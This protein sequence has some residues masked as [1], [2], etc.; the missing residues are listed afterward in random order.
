MKLA[1]ISHKPCWTSSNSASGYATD[2]GFPY[3]M[4]AL[5]E[6]FD[7]THLVVPCS[8]TNNLPG[9]ISLH[10]HNLSVR[11][12]QNPYGSGIWRKVFILPWLVL[13][14][15]I[16]FWEILQSDAVHTPI[17][18]D[19]GTIGMVLCVLMQKRL[20]VRHCGNWFVQTTVIE[21]F[22]KWFMERYAGG[23]RVMLVTGGSS[24][25]PSPSNPAIRWIFATTLS[26]QEL[27]ICKAS[28]AL[29]TQDSVR[30]IIVCRQ[31]WDKGTD[32]VIKSMPIVLSHFPKV[33]L[34]VVGDGSA[35]G[36]L[37]RLAKD[38]KV[39]DQII[40][41]GRVDHQQVLHLLG[42]AHL[43]C[44][45][46]SSSDGFPKVVHEALA[47]G[48]PVITTRVSVLPHLLEAGCGVLINQATPELVA[49]A[50]CNILRNSDKY[51]T[52]SAHALETAQRYSLEKWRDTI[53]DMLQSSWGK[54]KTSD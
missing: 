47:C 19:V 20:F 46:T 12:L 23:K 34:D 14:G 54:L 13:N 39:H 43:F 31:E 6:L 5:S 4:C 26:E 25:I 27:K 53:G 29:S 24:Q 16:L 36:G 18:G 45:P 40:F 33:S 21:R 3:Q 15:P 49:D 8:T 32:A 1:V 22:C 2:G 10:G 30:L 37:K 17:P 41:H 52:M 51:I 44:Y 28:R 7:E 38:L 11:S 9:E 35:L 42:R 50:I 48:L